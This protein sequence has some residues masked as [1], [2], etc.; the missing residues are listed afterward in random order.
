MGGEPAG[1]KVARISAK[2]GYN[3]NIFEKNRELGGALRMA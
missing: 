3:V 1:L 2:G